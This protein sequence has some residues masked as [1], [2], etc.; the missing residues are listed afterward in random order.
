MRRFHFLILS[1]VLVFSGLP[2][3]YSVTKPVLI[4]SYMSV[5]DWK[6]IG[7][8]VYAVPSREGKSPLNGMFVFEGEIPSG[9]KSFVSIWQAKVNTK[10]S[11]ILKSNKINTE[12]QVNGARFAVKFGTSTIPIRGEGNYIALLTILD[13]SNQEVTVEQ[14]SFSLNHSLY[15]FSNLRVAL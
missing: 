6:N 3:A 5:T 15:V 12:I 13:S 8:T 9:S 11:Q 1:V 4:N 10:P 14:T 7:D 2:S